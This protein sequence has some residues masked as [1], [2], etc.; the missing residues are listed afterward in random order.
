L[1]LAEGEVAVN[2]NW[3]R[4]ANALID[5]HPNKLIGHENRER[6]RE[7]MLSHLGATNLEIGAALGMSPESVGRHIKKLR[8]EWER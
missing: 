4:E 1:L 2:D 7:Y 8:Q 6:I 3:M 5:G